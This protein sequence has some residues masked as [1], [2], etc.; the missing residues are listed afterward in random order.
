MY[1]D[2]EMGNYCSCW[3]FCCSVQDKPKKSGWS[4]RAHTNEE[5]SGIHC[6]PRGL[7]QNHEEAMLGVRS[8]DERLTTR[9][10]ST[11]GTRKNAK[12]IQKSFTGVAC[13]KLTTHG[14]TRKGFSTDFTAVVVCA[15]QLSRSAHRPQHHHETTCPVLP[16]PGRTLGLCALFHGKVSLADF[17]FDFLRHHFGWCFT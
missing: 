16:K 12:F 4:T 1:L 11:L 5:R 17:V 10:K 13:E 15:T 14:H 9:R 6:A 8:S 3:T 2:E 7:I